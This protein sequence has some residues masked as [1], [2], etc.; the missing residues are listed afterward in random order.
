MKISREVK[1]GVI[2]ILSMAALFW[3]LNFLKGKNLFDNSRN[4]Y[5]IYDHVNGLSGNR[6]VNLNGYK[7][8]QVK[9]IY[10]H[11]DGSGRLIV[12]FKMTKDF[13]VTQG[14]KAEI[15]SSDLLGEKSIRLLLGK[16]D[17]LAVSGDTLIGDI[18]LSLTEEVNKQVAPLKAK[19]EKLLGSIDTVMVL[20]TGFLNEE[21]QGNFTKT[22]ESI[23]RSF[24]H[25]EHSIR[26]FDTTMTRSQ[27]GLVT[28]VENIAK[29]TTT[30]EENREALHDI[31][32]NLS[33]VSDSLSK[34]KF[35]KTFDQLDQA[36]AQANSVMTKL[37]DGSGS[38][39]KFINDPSVYENLARA[40]E[41]LNLLLLDVKYNPKRYVNFSL[42]GKVDDYDAAEIQALEEENETLRQEMNQNQSK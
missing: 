36:L 40:T 28:S 23:R 10:F 30:L 13:E 32:Q 17:Q 25:L 27:K 22:F 37:D 38:A 7:V 24:A 39:G 4:Y 14:T 11:P 19:A 33:S 16:S 20:A 6:P 21:T 5:A 2:A 35:K 34:V 12:N 9:E 42:F 31:F 1:V 3:G 29:I 15:Y 41:Q 26:E 18:E 8:G